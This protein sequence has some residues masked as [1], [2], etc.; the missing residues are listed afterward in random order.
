MRRKVNWIIYLFVIV[1]V[2][3][4][5][6]SA[7]AAPLELESGKY[8][9]GI[10]DKTFCIDSIEF[11]GVRLCNSER[12]MISP[13]T[14]IFIREDGKDSRLISCQFTFDGKIVDRPSGKYAGN[15]LS[16]EKTY[17]LGGIK[18]VSRMD[19]SA[20]GVILASRWEFVA[21]QP[22]VSFY[23]YTFSWSKIN[24]QWCVRFYNDISASG[25]FV[26]NEKF[27][28]VRNPGSIRWFA[29]FSSVEQKGMIGVLD[30]KAVNAGYSRFW[31]RA[32]SRVL[33]YDLV[34]PKNLS[35]HHKSSVYTIVLR[36]FSAKTEQ[37][38][39]TVGKMAESLV[40]D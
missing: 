27:Y 25:N 3:S 30:D 36:G 32:N 34:L 15:K 40:R 14:G 35:I 11:D 5:F 7:F 8:R 31:D 9:V 20:D 12:S 21:D 4:V 10:S 22:L 18:V 17:L 26:G 33:L 1:G 19:L 37:W 38:K 2:A 23:F 24:D 29:V 39:E 16:L 28:L 6:H 13:K